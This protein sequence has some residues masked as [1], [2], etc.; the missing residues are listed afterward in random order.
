MGKSL[1]ILWTVCILVWVA[2]ILAYILSLFMHNE[3]I[4]AIATCR[5]TDYFA[6]PIDFETV[7]ENETEKECWKEPIYPIIEYSGVI[8]MIEKWKPDER[9]DC[10]KSNTVCSIK[11]HPELRVIH[12]EEWKWTVV[13]ADDFT[14]CTY[15]PISD[16]GLLEEYH[17][18]YD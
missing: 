3:K 12:P 14:Y 18:L 16:K 5:Y 17:R 7:C 13:I 4:W 1:K 6:E 10:N 2:G 15:E 11:T 9:Y 8:T